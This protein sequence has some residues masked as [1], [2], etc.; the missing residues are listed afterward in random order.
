MAVFISTVGF[1][2]VSL[3]KSIKGIKSYFAVAKVMALIKIKS[4][5]VF[6]HSFIP[7]KKIPAMAMRLNTASKTISS[8]LF[9][10]SDGLNCMTFLLLVH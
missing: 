1:V 4:G 9:W 7:E 10:R 5:N 8:V 6:Y 3:L 2:T